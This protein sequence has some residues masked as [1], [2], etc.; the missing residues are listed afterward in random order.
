MILVSFGIEIVY[1]TIT[2]RGI[3]LVREDAKDDTD[4]AQK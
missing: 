2:G 3:H 1:R 4:T